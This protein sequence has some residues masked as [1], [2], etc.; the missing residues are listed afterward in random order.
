MN[1]RLILLRALAHKTGKLAQLR[2]AMP[3]KQGWISAVRQALGMTAKQLA[4]RVGL[5]QPRIAKMELNE[6]NLKISTMK[7]IAEGLDCDFVYGFVPK[8]SLQE[9]IKRQARKKAEA[10]LSSVNTNMA[11]EDQLA[12]DPHILMDM[13]DEMIAKNIRRIWDK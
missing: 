4:E 2:E 5:S 10:I 13:A 12:D 9:T 8:C 6:N 1:K 11:L 3:P 7:K